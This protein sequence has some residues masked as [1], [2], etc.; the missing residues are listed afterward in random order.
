MP[1]KA[2]PR[3]RLT[4]DEK[5]SI[6]LKYNRRAGVHKSTLQLAKEFG[7]NKQAISYILKHKEKFQNASSGGQLGKRKSIKGALNFPEIDEPLLE[8]FRN[9]RAADKEVTGSIL[10]AGAK[11]IAMKLSL[12]GDSI[13]DSWIQRWRDRH[14]IR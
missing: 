2:L 12:E 10:L 6:I 9:L 3:R 5:N 14:G 7:V 4:L 11:K 1:P 8:W 13:S